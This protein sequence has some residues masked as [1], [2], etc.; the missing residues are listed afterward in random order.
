MEL[1]YKRAS[2]VID[3]LDP[4]HSE[5][6]NPHMKLSRNHWISLT[7]ICTGFP[8]SLF[9][10]SIQAHPGQH[11]TQRI[12]PNEQTVPLDIGTIP[13]IPEDERVTV[14]VRVVDAANYLIART[15]DW[16]QNEAI[17]TS[18]TTRQTAIDSF[19]RARRFY[20]NV[21]RRTSL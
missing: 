4:T 10:S 18:P 6:K 13:N 3:K 21:L 7:S 11:G 14:K 1:P 5:V 2:S 16:A 15:L 20:L 19:Q 17:W 9:V 12:A 8:I